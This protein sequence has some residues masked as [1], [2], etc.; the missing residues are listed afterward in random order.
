M[1]PSAHPSATKSKPRTIRRA[2]R[3]SATETAPISGETV[4]MLGAVDGQIDFVM[5]PGY[6]AVLATGFGA[7]ALVTDI[8]TP[9][10][11]IDLQVPLLESDRGHAAYF[12]VP[13][14]RRIHIHQIKYPASLNPLGASRPT[15]CCVFSTQ[16][17]GLL[18]LY[19]FAFQTMDN[20]G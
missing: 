17:R 5:P 18:A 2:S 6:D 12:S 9:G 4:L 19:L 14:G 7:D 16:L 15:K 13:A 3:S 11:P 1:E 20:E 10:Q 8:T